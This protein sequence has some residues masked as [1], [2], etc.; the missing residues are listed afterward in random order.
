MPFVIDTR[1]DEDKEWYVVIDPDK[2]RVIS[3]ERSFGSEEEAKKWAKANLEK[4][5]EENWRVRKV[6]SPSWFMPGSKKQNEE[7]GDE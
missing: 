4:I 6:T 2:S 3:V 7:S 1:V 5:T